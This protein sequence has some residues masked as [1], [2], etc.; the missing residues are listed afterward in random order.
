MAALQPRSM[1]FLVTS[2]LFW[3]LTGGYDQNRSNACG[4]HLDLVAAKNGEAYKQNQINYPMKNLKLRTLMATVLAL[5]ICVTFAGP[6]S[7]RIKVTVRGKGPDVLLIPGL[8]SSSAVWDATAKQL[9]NHFRLHIIQVAGFAG[10][11]AGANATGA[12]LQPMVDAIDLYIKTNQ[13]KSL[14]MVGHS[15]GGLVGMMLAVQ[16]PRTLTN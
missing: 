10:S 4:A 1:H 13:I 6:V 11:P 8:A 5:Q 7:D 3:V 12:I 2:R 9:E 14:K 15:L 16:S